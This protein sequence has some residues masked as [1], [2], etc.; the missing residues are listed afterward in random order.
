MTP[1]Q[2]AERLNSLLALAQKR[3]KEIGRDDA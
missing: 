3:Q 1:S 2:R